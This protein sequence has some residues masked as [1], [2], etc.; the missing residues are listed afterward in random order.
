VVSSV[1][2]LLFTILINVFRPASVYALS[3]GCTLLL[4]GSVADVVGSRS[5]YLTGCGLLVAFTIGCGLSHTGIQLV[6][7]RAF[8]GIAISFCLPSAVSIITTTFSAGQRRN[9]AFAC[10]GA[11]QPAGFSLGLV[12]GG[13]LID[14]TGW[15]VGYYVVA[16]ANV[17]IV[18]TAIWGL[19]RD[20]RKVAPITWERL[21]L[22]IDWVGALVAS[23]SLGLLSYVFA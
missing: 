12:L 20:P 17:F 7:F 21:L 22:E 23:T 11:S 16:G 3:C 10:L 6:V 1:R 14:S 18:I 15:R 9:V 13:V 8:S 4:S 5:M 19:P 2:G